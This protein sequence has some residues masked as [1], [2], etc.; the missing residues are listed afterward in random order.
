MKIP[1]GG[2]VAKAEVLK[3]KYGAIGISGG[4]RWGGDANQIPSAG[5]C[6]YFLEAH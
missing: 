4:V 6:G 2:G 3:E 1:G 5:G